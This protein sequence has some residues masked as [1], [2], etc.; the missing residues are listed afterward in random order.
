[1]EIQT[2]MCQSLL[3]IWIFSSEYWVPGQVW[4][5]LRHVNKLAPCNFLGRAHMGVRSPMRMLFSS[6]RKDAGALLQG[7]GSDG[8]SVLWQLE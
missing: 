3:L 8:H 1:M 7:C 2:W 6:Y 5:F 4:N